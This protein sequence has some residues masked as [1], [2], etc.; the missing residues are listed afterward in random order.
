MLLCLKDM[1][2]GDIGFRGSGRQRSYLVFF[3][4][5]G[6]LNKVRP[7]SDRPVIIGFLERR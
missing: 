4:C 2:I 6:F 1:G 3:M 7:L 5:F